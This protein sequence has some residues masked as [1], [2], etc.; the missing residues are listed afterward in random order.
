MIETIV[1]DHLMEELNME[2]VYMEVPKE[3]L[4]DRFV[5]IEKTGGQRTD[6][7]GQATFAVQ[8]YATTMLDAAMLNEEVMA[9]MDGLIKEQEVTRSAYDTDYNFTDTATKRYRYQCVYDI[10]HYE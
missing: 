8:S 10:T 5:V 4:P 3:N 1:L 7:I 2:D 6:H 9:A